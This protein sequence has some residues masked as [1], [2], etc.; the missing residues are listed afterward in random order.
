M[1]KIQQGVSVT[2]VIPQAVLAMAVAATVYKDV[3]G[4]NTIVTYVDKGL[5]ALRTKHVGRDRVGMLTTK[6]REA[7]RDEFV[8]SLADPQGPDERLEIQYNASSDSNL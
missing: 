3:C 6:L 2:N 8:V 5:I 1:I 7:L 4:V